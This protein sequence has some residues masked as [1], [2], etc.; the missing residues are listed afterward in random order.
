MLGGVRE[1]RQVT[2]AF[3]RSGQLPLM[4]GTGPRPS[5]RLYLSPRS[6]ESPQKICILVVY[7]YLIHTE[8]ADVPV[9]SHVPP[10][11]PASIS[12]SQSSSFPILSSS[13]DELASSRAEHNMDSESH[14]EGARLR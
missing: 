4:P 2:G 11:K 5:T 3:D 6:Q 9:V 14:G 13:H 12:I 7:L 1:E 10:A 8:R